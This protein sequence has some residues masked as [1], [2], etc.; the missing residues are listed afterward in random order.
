M[1]TFCAQFKGQD[2]MAPNAT[3]TNRKTDRIALMMAIFC[4][5]LPNNIYHNSYL[6]PIEVIKYMKETLISGN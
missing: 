2:A 4:L 6:R 5:I 3:N 1:G